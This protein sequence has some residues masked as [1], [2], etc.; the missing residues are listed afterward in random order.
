LPVEEPRLGE[1]KMC[2]LQKCCANCGKQLGTLLVVLTLV[3]FLASGTAAGFSG[4]FVFGDVDFMGMPKFMLYVG[5]VASFLLA[6]ISLCG[7]VGSCKMKV[8]AL[9]RGKKGIYDHDDFEHSSCKWPMYVFTV[10]TTIFAFMH[11]ACG[12]FALDYAGEMEG[13]ADVAGYDYDGNNNSTRNAVSA[14]SER[15]IKYINREFSAP[16]PPGCSPVSECKD[17][18]TYGSWMETQEFFECCGYDRAHPYTMTY[19]KLCNFPMPGD[20]RQFQLEG[21]DNEDTTTKL[22]I[23][24]LETGVDTCSDAFAAMFDD[25]AVVFIVIGTFELV[26]ACLSC[27]LI[28]T[29]RCF[30]AHRDEEDFRLN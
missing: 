26:V 10:F 29:A 18:F 4:Y 30:R 9:D 7:L 5:T 13:V 6:S 14:L 22:L 16:G 17:P 11:L 12:G 27:S 8:T 23:G 25:A 20:G 21:V 2:N 24:S 15:V 1:R 19:Q 28:C 3:M